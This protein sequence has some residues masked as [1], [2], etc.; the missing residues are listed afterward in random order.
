MG[1]AHACTRADMPY[2]RFADG[3]TR[4]EELHVGSETNVTASIIVNVPAEHFKTDDTRPTTL[5]AEPIVSIC[6]S[7]EMVNL[8]CIKAGK[9]DDTACA[10]ADDPEK[11]SK[12]DN[13]GHGGLPSKSASMVDAPVSETTITESSIAESTGNNKI[14]DAL[15]R[16]P[17]PEALL[18]KQPLDRASN[19]VNG[20]AACNTKS[21]PFSAWRVLQAAKLRDL[22]KQD[23][24]VP[25]VGTSSA[26][27]PQRSARCEPG[28]A[29]D[30]AS[31]LA[32]RGCK[33]DTCD[34]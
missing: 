8:A 1:I 31:T 9:T 15:I 22:P 33:C 25:T 6:N 23:T 2:E 20:N 29:R 24:T 32:K 27:R 18:H 13:I 11:L 26:R 30:T 34:K 21:M 14:N 28:Y 17:A 5:L 16:L 19:A 7:G 10:K 12:S 4:H 3:D